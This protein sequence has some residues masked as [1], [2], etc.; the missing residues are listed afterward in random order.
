M[1]KISVLFALV[2]TLALCILPCFADTPAVPT[3]SADISSDVAVTYTDDAVTTTG[4]DTMAIIGGADGPTAVL[5]ST[6]ED[7]GFGFHPENFVPNLYYMLVGMV[8][9]FIV[10]GIIVL[11][12]MLLN[13]LFSDKP[14]KDE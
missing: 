5:I 9:I 11:A 13:K 10:I 6:G 14:K 3:D 12:T 4:S 8:G 7:D 1:K 2:L